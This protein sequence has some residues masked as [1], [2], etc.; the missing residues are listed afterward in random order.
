MYSQP[1]TTAKNPTLNE[2]FQDFVI[3][4]KIKKGTVEHYGDL[5]SRYAGDWL[6]LPIA[7]IGR[8]DIQ[9]RHHFITHA[10]GPVAANVT[11][12]VIS[13]IMTY[14]MFRY[15]GLL[16]ENPVLALTQ[17]RAWN[18]PKPKHRYIK[19]HE[20]GRWYMA[21][22]DLIS[23]NLRDSLLLM[24]FTGLRKGE[25]A[26]LL[27]EDVQF[28]NRSFVVRDTKNGEDHQ[29]PMCSFVY[30]MLSYRHNKAISA[31]VFPNQSLSGPM[32]SNSS[33]YERVGY[34]CGVKFSPHDLRRTFV[35][36]A[37]FVKTPHYHLKQLVNHAG[38]TDVTFKHY[39]IKDIEPL[40]EASE[41]ICYAL[42]HYLGITRYEPIH[43]PSRELPALYTPYRQP[44]ALTC[45]SETY[46]IT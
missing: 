43:R 8:E 13:S 36:I 19:N 45:K 16:T 37:V 41:R 25:A 38:G 40:R 29:M 42:K 11:M 9:M 7:S 39:I 24:L 31:W 30:E 21:L 22:N 4:R 34:K 44:P 32:S 2:V 33:S 3:Y 46:V 1:S 28:A 5:L 15:R 10:N 6:H 27:W 35:T 17:L 26:S 20:L 23:D 12:R 18:K 14:A